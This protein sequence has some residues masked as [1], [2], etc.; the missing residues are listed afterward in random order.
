MGEKRTAF[1]EKRAAALIP[2][3]SFRSLPLLDLSSFT[4]PL[5]RVSGG[6]ALTLQKSVY[7]RTWRETG[8]KKMGRARERKKRAPIPPGSFLF[9]PFLLRV[10]FFWSRSLSLPSRSPML[11][12]ISLASRF[13]SCFPCYFSH[14]VGKAKRSEPRTGERF[15]TCHCLNSADSLPC[16]A[17]CPC[18]SFTCAATCLLL[19]ACAQP[20]SRAFIPRFYPALSSRIFPP[21]NCFLDQS[22][23]PTCRVPTPFLPLFPCFLFGVALLLLPLGQ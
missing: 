9:F 10:F 16:F 8:E 18:L 19:S 17:A 2:R 7:I 21:L 15:Q 14:L 23:P 22:P 5:F 1:C 13:V 6:V 3:V 11:S 12:Y 20:F 4:C